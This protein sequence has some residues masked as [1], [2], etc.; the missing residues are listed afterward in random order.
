MRTLV[1]A[2]LADITDGCA[3]DHV[4]HSEPLDSLVLGDAARAIRAAH[5][6]D[7]AAPL[8]VPPAISSFLGLRKF[9]SIQN[10]TGPPTPGLQC[11]T[12]TDHFGGGRI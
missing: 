1:D 4:P 10:I 3:L 11:A 12:R 2:G 5:E 8:L 9:V 6:S 7:M